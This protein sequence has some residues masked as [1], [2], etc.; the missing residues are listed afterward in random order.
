ASTIRTYFRIAVYTWCMLVLAAYT[1]FFIYEGILHTQELST[2]LL[3]LPFLFVQLSA[4]FTMLVLFLPPKTF[5]W[6]T[7]TQSYRDGFAKILSYTQLRPLPIVATVAFLAISVGVMA[8]GSQLG[9]TGLA[10]ALIYAAALLKP[11]LLYSKP[12]PTTP[13]A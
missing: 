12:A 9:Q 7:I 10:F 5:D 13:Q 4:V 2:L 3:A 11:S 8:I 6:S 1:G